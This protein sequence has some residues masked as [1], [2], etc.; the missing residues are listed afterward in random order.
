MLTLKHDMA[1]RMDQ[2]WPQ[3]SVE[4]GH[5]LFYEEMFLSNFEPP[6]YGNHAEEFGA[7]ICVLVNEEFSLNVLKLL[8]RVM[9]MIHFDLIEVFANTANLVQPFSCFLF[10]R[11]SSK[12]LK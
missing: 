2:E 3:T 9:K 1:Q 6:E 8:A 11:N 10:G 7:G 12:I 4:T 5:I